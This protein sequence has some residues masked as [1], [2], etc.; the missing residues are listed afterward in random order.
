MKSKLILLTLFASL[1]LAGCGLNVNTTDP[2]ASKN[3]QESNN[4]EVFI[5][6]YSLDQSNYTLDPLVLNE[7]WVERVWFRTAEGLSTG[8]E[9]TDSYQLCFTLAENN[10]TPFATEHYNDWNMNEKI[11]NRYV[12]HR[13]EVYTLFLEGKEI[14]ERIDLLL[15]YGSGA[16][17]K[18]KSAGTITF[19]IADTIHINNL[20]KEPVDEK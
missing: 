12:G 5:A 8:V 6:P 16:K 17:N 2:V 13:G 1:C 20:I 4:K 19:R 9:P 15:S 14:P 11:S 10:N 7:A 18:F 3:I